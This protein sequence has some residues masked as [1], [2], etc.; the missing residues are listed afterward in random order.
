MHGNE[1]TAERILSRKEHDWWMNRIGRVLIVKGRYFLVSSMSSKAI[2][3]CKIQDW[4]GRILCIR[5]RDEYEVKVGIQELSK[6]Q[7]EPYEQERLDGDLLTNTKL[8]GDI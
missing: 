8:L 4:D 2:E 1:H 5:Y 6:E 7:A 3:D